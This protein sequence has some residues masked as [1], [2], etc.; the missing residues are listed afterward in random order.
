MRASGYTTKLYSMILEF[1]T[2]NHEKALTAGDVFSYVHSQNE[3]INRATVYRNLDKLI[4]E[5]KILKYVT[6]DGKMASYILRDETH[7]CGEHF[8]LQCSECGK[9]IHLDCGYVDDFIK[10]ISEEH[11]FDLR[12]SSSIIFGKCRECSKKEEIAD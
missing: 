10:H 2:N 11:G 12:C 3:K 7:K 1:F 8:H 5:G 6:D 9:V 4:S